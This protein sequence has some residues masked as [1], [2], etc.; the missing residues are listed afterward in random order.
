MGSEHAMDT[1]KG[2]NGIEEDA[3]AKMHRMAAG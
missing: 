1:T 2:K 3:I